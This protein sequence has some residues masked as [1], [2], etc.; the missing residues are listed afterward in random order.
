MKTFKEFLEKR[1]AELYNE[2]NWQGIKKIGQNAL[3]GGAL[4]GSALGLGGKATAQDLPIKK[5]SN[6]TTIVQK[7]TQV[8]PSSEESIINFEAIKSSVE[9]YGKKILEN[10]STEKGKQFLNTNK[11]HWEIDGT[12]IPSEFRNYNLHVYLVKG[13][14]D[15]KIPQL[16]SMNIGANKDYIKAKII[17]DTQGKQPLMLIH[18]DDG[19]IFFAVT[20]K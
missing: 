9:N 12:K 15:S 3:L 14:T 2:I 20:E 5:D 6:R 17:K 10:I 7:Q 11:G 19:T 13:S 18:N 16:K 4:L 8:K 1:D